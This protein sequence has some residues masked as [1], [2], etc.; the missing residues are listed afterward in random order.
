MSALAKGRVAS[1]CQ[2]NIYIHMY[3]FGDVSVRSAAYYISFL[4]F[5]T[6]VR[7]FSWLS[8]IV[9]VRRP[10][11][12]LHADAPRGSALDSG[13]EPAVRTICSLVYFSD[14]R[15]HAAA[16]SSL[17]EITKPTTVISADISFIV[18]LP[19]V[20]WS[21]CRALVRCRGAML[22]KVG[23]GCTCRH[24]LELA[25]NN[26]VPAAFTQIMWA[27]GFFRRL[28]PLSQLSCCLNL[29]SPA[30]LRWLQRF[31]PQSPRPAQLPCH[32]PATV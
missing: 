2:G 6:F 4:S 19:H 26:V 9:T 29:H 15:A 1:R 17:H 23:G 3:S 11:D 8:P 27:L 21:G 24:C 18:I 28:V 16:A 32:V 10:L 30:S 31:P 20:L 14:Q 13:S 25:I 5:S 22:P 7:L 12:I